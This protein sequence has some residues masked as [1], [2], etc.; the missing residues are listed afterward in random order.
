[1]D[2][3]AV[4]E[5]VYD[6]GDE[7]D[8]TPP[9]VSMDDDDEN[10][11]EEEEV[12]GGTVSELHP[13]LLCAAGYRMTRNGDDARSEETQL[14]DE[15]FFHLVDAHMSV[16]RDAFPLARAFAA[17]GWRLLTD[18]RLLADARRLPGQS[19]SPFPSARLFW[20]LLCHKGWPSLAEM[21][22]HLLRMHVIKDQCLQ[23]DEYRHVVD[24]YRAVGHACPTCR[25]DTATYA[26]P[27][28]LRHCHRCSNQAAQPLQ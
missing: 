2:L 20:C 19:L 18:C 7:D 15:L 27:E 28:Q 25:D 5:C 1:M 12:R 26:T 22:S 13:C 3:V 11:A 4:A 8:L 23:A 21:K 16:A 17:H 6:D 24:A 9:T 10:E 14:A